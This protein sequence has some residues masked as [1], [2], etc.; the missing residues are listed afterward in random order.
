[1]TGQ[2]IVLMQPIVGALERFVADTMAGHD[3]MFRAA[4]RELA[5]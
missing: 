3:L 4:M 2:S 5:G 1:M